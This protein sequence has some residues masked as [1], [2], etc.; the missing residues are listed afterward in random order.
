MAAINFYVT[1]VM[2]GLSLIGN[3]HKKVMIQIPG[4]LKFSKLSR[5]EN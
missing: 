1:V 4:S 3:R 5:W 2:G